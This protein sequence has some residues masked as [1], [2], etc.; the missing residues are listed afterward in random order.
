MGTPNFCIQREVGVQFHSFPFGNRVVQVLFVEE[1]IHFPL[2]EQQRFQK[3]VS[4]WSSCFGTVGSLASLECWD[5]G[6]VPGLAQWVKD[7]ATGCRSNL[8][9]TLDLGTPYVLGRSQKKK[10]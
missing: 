6:S 1:T 2:N 10:K 4:C 7:L 9:L 3:S 5:A 8:D